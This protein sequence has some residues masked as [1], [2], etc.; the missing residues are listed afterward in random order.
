MAAFP[1][2]RRAVIR[3]LLAR[4]A[5]SL[6]LLWLVL[7]ALFLLLH[8][9]PGDPVAAFEDPRVPA[10][11]RARLRA[12]YGLDRPL[13]E[14]YVRWLG[15]ALSGEWGYSFTYHRPVAAVLRDTVPLTLSLALT[16]LLLEYALGLG[17]GVAAAA[18]AGSS[19]D[20]AIRAASLAIWAIPSFWLGLMAIAVGAVAWQI[21]PPGGLATVGAEAWS[22]PRRAADFAWH[23]ALPAAAIGLP[24]A[25]AT[26]RFVRATVLE[27]LAEPF[28]TAALARGLSR[29]RVLW[30]HALR[31]G[32]API[33]QLA[34][35]S[36]AGLLSGSLTVEVV[37]GWPGVGR[38]AYEALVARDYPLL[39]AAT[40]LS[41]GL[42]LVGS[43]L[44]ETLHAALDPRVR[45]A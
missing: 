34:G 1:A 30:R 19:L 42:V 12:V 21:F 38:A 25:A 5:A 35:L 22:W 17:L 36:V 39:L 6:V 41:A 28:I 33:A 20:H 45:D 23:L 32:M 31:A 14:Q 27:Q 2:A 13:A 7:S 16:A 4:L 18:R 9:L 10:E 26:A 37:F 11:Q 29:R 44:A 40:A 3:P 43:F 15:G 24:A 8:L